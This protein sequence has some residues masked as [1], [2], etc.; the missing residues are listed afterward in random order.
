VRFAT[1]RYPIDRATYH[2][3]AETSRIPDVAGLDDHDLP[4]LL[5]GFHAREVLHVT[6]GSVLNQE[7]LR[8]PFFDT[9][10]RNEEEYTQVVEAHFDRH[11]NPFN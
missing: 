9:L 1:G 4:G 8:A 5:E 11:L 7:Q 10:R 6:Y 2:V 3:S